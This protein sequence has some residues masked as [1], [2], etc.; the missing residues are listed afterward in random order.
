MH[1]DE[2]NACKDAMKVDLFGTICM[3]FNYGYAKGYRAAVSEMKRR[4]LCMSG[5]RFHRVI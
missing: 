4:R 3:L 1:A 2:M 5:I